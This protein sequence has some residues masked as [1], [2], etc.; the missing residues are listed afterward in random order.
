M[1]R[2]MPVIH[3]A[4]VAHRTPGRLRIVIP[5]RRDDA[6]FFGQLEDRLL[7]CS[8]IERAR[9]NPAAACVVIHHRAS[10]HWNDLQLPNSG[11]AVISPARTDRC[12][13]D[14][15]EQRGTK[16]AAARSSLPAVTNIDLAGMI[17]QAAGVALS[18]RPL[19]ALA[20]LLGEAV[21]KWII[22][23]ILAP[24]MKPA[25]CAVLQR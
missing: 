1:G 16:R 25:G 23:S 8:G 3:L 14:P 5:S 19:A 17:V 15:D 4:Y 10:F 12:S 9:S 20:H 6:A 11:L 7:A 13:A 18:R 2:T 24:K 21:L 22:S